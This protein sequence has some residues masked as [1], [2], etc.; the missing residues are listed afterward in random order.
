MTCPQLP[1]AIWSHIRSFSGDTGYEQKRTAQVMQYVDFVDDS[2]G[3]FHFQFGRDGY[4][5]TI[6][7]AIE[8]NH[9][10]KPMAKC[11]DELCSTC[12]IR[13][14]SCIN[15]VPHRVRP[16]RLMRILHRDSNGYPIQA[17]K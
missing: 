6:V 1:K 11:S 16:R 17:S 13:D 15:A 9:F 8:P 4:A 10:R 3:T 12:N 2:H 5:S 7:Y 14:W